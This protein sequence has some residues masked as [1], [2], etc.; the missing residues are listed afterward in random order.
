MN[1]NAII[2]THG[3]LNTNQAKTAHGLVRDTSQYHV[4]GIIDAVSAGR[5]VRQ[6]VS[7]APRPIPIY[8]SLADCQDDLAE[9]INYC[10]VGVAGHGG[11][12][13]DGM[14]ATVKEVLNNKMHVINGLHEYLSDM[15]EIA[16]L[17]EENGVTITDI[18]KA[19]PKNQLHFWEGSIYDI[20]ALKIAVLGTDCNLGKR[21]TTRLLL[22]A[23]RKADINAEMIYTG[24][25]GWMQDNRFG[26]IFDSTLNDFISGEIE[27]TIEQCY[28]EASPQVILLEGQSSLRN[29]GGPG[30]SEFLV[31]GQAKQ[32]V[33]QHAP[34]RKYFSG[35][36]HLNAEIPSLESEIELIRMYGSE[37]IGLTLNTENLS[38][39]EARQHQQRYQQT[40]GITTLLPLHDDF[41]ELINAILPLL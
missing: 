37:V 14:L 25:T 9:P 34:A 15:P 1:K 10:L 21:T 20:P 22:H 12:I 35:Y 16:A 32:V 19:K 26:F 24:Q 8:A 41:T 29:P 6:I 36:E 31:S 17:A 39:E 5:D 2:I 40:L 28:R 33:L 7:Q 11:K 27:A 23:L 18:R 30:G 38:L 4:L 13:P 3:L